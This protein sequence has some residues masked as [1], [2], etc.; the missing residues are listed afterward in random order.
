LKL[1]FKEARMLLQAAEYYDEFAETGGDRTNDPEEE[2]ALHR[3][4]AKLSR[5]VRQ[6]RSREFPRE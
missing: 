3:G 1:T 2:K 4:L 6:L 5:H